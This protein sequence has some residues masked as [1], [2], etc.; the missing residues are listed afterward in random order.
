MRSLRGASVRGHAECL[1]V[2]GKNITIIDSKQTNFTKDIASKAAPAPLL[3]LQDQSPRYGIPVHIALAFRF[4]CAPSKGRNRKSAAARWAWVLL[5]GT[6]GAG[7]RFQYKKT[8][9]LPFSRAFRECG[10]FSGRPATATLVDFVFPGFVHHSGNL[11]GSVI[12]SPC[13]RD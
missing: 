10:S 2:I 7:P 1:I 12:S 9:D 5:L 13:L 6:G 3:R 4:A 11:H 8:G